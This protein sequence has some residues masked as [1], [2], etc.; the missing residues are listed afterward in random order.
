MRWVRSSNP[1]RDGGHPERIHP[2]QTANG[3]DIRSDVWSFGITM[4]ELATGEFPYPKWDS[5]FQL[6]TYVL[7]N[8]PPS[9]PERLPRPGGDIVIDPAVEPDNWEFSPEF[10]DFV[11]QCLRR[12]FHERPKYQALKSHPFFRRALADPVNVSKYFTAVLSKIPPNTRLEDLVD[13]NE[14]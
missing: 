5:V 4:V 6:L 14:W 12:D 10:R 13:T 9:V 11:N 1:D 8:D 3:Y 7:K 2:D